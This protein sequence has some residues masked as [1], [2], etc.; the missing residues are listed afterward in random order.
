MPFA[1]IRAS[2]EQGKRIFLFGVISLKLPR[3]PAKE[4]V[5]K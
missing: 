4:K 1:K 5:D 3:N 2:S